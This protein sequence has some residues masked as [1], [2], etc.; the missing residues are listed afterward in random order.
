YP[1][2]DYRRLARLMHQLR[3]VKSDGEVALIRQAA[4]IT[5][6]GFR[7]A[8]RFV[9][10]GVRETALEAEFAHEFIR[11]DGGFAYLP[12][13]ASGANACILHYTRNDQ[14]CRKGVLLLLDVGAAY[15]NYNAD[16]T[17]TIPVSGRFTRR[18]K[19]VYNAVLRVFRRSVKA[20]APGKPHKDWQQEA[21]HMIEQEL[22]DLGLL[23]ARAI[24]RQDP[25]TPAFK[26]YFMHGIG[27]PIGL[28][29]HDVGLITKP[30]SPG[31]VMTV[32]P[33]I[34]IRQ[35]G[36]AVR[37]ENT[38]LLGENGTL[39]LMADIPIEAD[40]IEEAMNR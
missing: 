18:Q 25:D 30:I 4:A 15:A 26:K 39:D 35:E 20:L 19:Q 8:L 3:V 6:K 12:I 33:G 34:Y 13:I 10:P 22:L 32:E 2:H 5:G 27:H 38:V 17:R 28:D 31:W 11:R 21:E 14:V 37:L 24:K 23:T 9:K 1:L 40:E 16:M 29:V 7:R 36:F